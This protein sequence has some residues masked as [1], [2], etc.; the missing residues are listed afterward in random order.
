MARTMVAQM[1]SEES[2]AVRYRVT[3]E[4]DFEH[5]EI[6]VLALDNLDKSFTEGQKSLGPFSAVMVG[7]ILQSYRRNGVGPKFCTFQS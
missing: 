1:L 4:H 6:T 7:K 5:S 3:S 2:R